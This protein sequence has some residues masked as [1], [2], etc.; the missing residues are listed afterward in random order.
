VATS[1]SERKRGLTDNLAPV[2]SY[3]FTPLFLVTLVVFLAVMAGLGKSPFTDREFLLLFNAM[4]AL[5]IALVLFNVSERKPTAVTRLFDPL[6]AALIFV[7]IAIDAIALSA[8]IGRL[9][10]FGASPNRIALLGENVLFLLNL[11]GLAVQYVRFFARRT[12]FAQVENWTVRYLPVYAAWLAAVV[13]LFPVI[14]GYS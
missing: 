3:I 11:V 4:L 7:A 1:L 5:V 10:T 9:S 13:F 2:L 14:F 8:I 12:G 6:N